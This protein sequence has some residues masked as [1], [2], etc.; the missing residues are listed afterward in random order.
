MHRDPDQ[1]QK[2]TESEHQHEERPAKSECKQG[3]GLVA[4]E[5]LAVSPNTRGN[6]GGSPKQ[7]KDKKCLHNVPMWLLLLDMSEARVTTM[8][9]VFDLIAILLVLTAAFAWTN[10][11]FVRLPHSIGM[12]VIGLLASLALIVAELLFPS[13]RLYNELVGLLRQ[14]D[15]EHAVLNGMLAFLLFAGALHVDFNL[16]RSR[17]WPVSLMA[18]AGTLISTLVV[19]LGLWL[20]SLILGP[21]IPL[22]WALVFGALISPTDPVAVL[23]ILKTMKVP[24]SLET[25]M[26]GEALF[27]DGVGVVVFTALLMLAAP[28]GGTPSIADV[29]ELFFLEAVGGG[30]LG[31]V[32]GYVAY[33]A[34]RAIDDYPIEVM[35]SIALVM[36]CYSLASLLHMSGPI[37]VVVAGLLVGNRG[38]Q[39]ALTDLTQRYLFGYW[40]LVDHTLNSILFLLIGL[41]VLI[42]RFDV[43]LLG[44]AT[45]CIPLVLFG[46]FLATAAPILALRRWIDFVNGSVVVLTW[47]GLRG[48]ISI[49]LALSLPETLTKPFLLAATYLVVI[50]TIIVQGLTLKRVASFHLETTAAEGS[51]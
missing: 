22:V 12:L 6:N 50:F 8:L 10:V 27:N 25:D 30:I 40:T 37:A 39:D 48:G 36:G 32:A 4:V 43:K 29:T 17:I 13:L 26:A 44:L 19:G 1:P 5:L 20:G 7:P 47:G 24:A 2:D 41:E 9:S 42:L 38:P 31:F 18:S 15:F 21:A 34:L 16:L 3:H 35:I 33:R 14:V 46:R 45:A 23:A 28:T 11:R 51:T 49:A